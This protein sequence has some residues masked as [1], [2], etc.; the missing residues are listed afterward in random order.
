MRQIKSPALPEL[1]SSKL[2]SPNRFDTKYH[3]VPMG[4]KRQRRDAEY[5]PPSSEVVMNEWRHTSVPLVRRNGVYMDNFT[6]YQ[7]SF[8]E[9]KNGSFTLRDGRKTSQSQKS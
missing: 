7:K 9:M 2:N 3:L 6:L 4:V 8:S 1:T 5:L